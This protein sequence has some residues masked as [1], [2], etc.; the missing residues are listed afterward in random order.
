MDISSLRDPKLCRPPPR[1]FE[2]GESVNHT[3]EVGVVSFHCSFPPTQH[4]DSETPVQ[5]SRQRLQFSCRGRSIG[6]LEEKEDQLANDDLEEA[7]QT[8][9]PNFF[10]SGYGLAGS[11]GFQVWAGT[12]LLV[13]ALLWPRP[14]ADAVSLMGLQTQ[15]AP[16]LDSS[17]ACRILEL[18]SGIGVVGTSLAAAGAEVLLTDLATLIDNATYPNLIQN[19]NLYREEAAGEH[20]EAMSTAPDQSFTFHDAPRWLSSKDGATGV[21]VGKGW[22]ST[23]YL[24]WRMPIDDQLLPHHYESLDLIVASDCV[25][26]VSMLDALLD[27]VEALFSKQERAPRLVMSFQRRDTKEGDE[28]GTFTTVRR[29]IN[30]VESRGLSIECVAWRPVRVESEAQA[31]VSYEDKEVFVFMIQ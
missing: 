12:R 31:E 16:V 14:G 24:D 2:C 17:R 9:D 28:S 21:P 10:D 7:H 13:E 11:T 1:G 20:T 15:I 27:T 19:C 5:M 6:V 25:W 18:G 23:A 22:A 26:L 4:L 8:V 30:S 3:G 29:V